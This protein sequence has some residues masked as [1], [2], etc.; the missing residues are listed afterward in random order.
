MREPLLLNERSCLF[1]ISQGNQVEFTRLFN[2]YKDK[3]YT[4]AYKITESA[5]LAEEIVQDVFL[6]I[7]QGREKLPQIDN[8]EA[9][10][11]TSIRNQTFTALRR[12]A[13][14]PRVTNDLSQDDIAINDEI[15]AYLQVREH[16]IML[17]MAMEKLPPQQGSVFK[18]IKID[19]LTREEAAAKLNL[20]PASVK[21]HLALAMPTVRS[22]C[23]AWMEMHLLLLWVVEK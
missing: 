13:K 8:L 5:A 4:I 11:Y 23:I 10:L 12:M 2:A 15:D 17:Q 3:F 1:E 19:G 16:Q 14:Q 9:Y 18:L 6:K 21:A 22:F 20:S 7:W